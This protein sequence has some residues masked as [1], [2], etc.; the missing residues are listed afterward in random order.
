MILSKASTRLPHPTARQTRST[1]A[2]FSLAVFTHDLSL[3]LGLPSFTQPSTA[4]SQHCS[5]HAHV[6]A[7]NRLPRS[8]RRTRGAPTLLASCRGATPDTREDVGTRPQRPGRANRRATPPPPNIRPL[9]GHIPAA[10]A[11]AGDA[12]CRRCRESGGSGLF[13]CSARSQHTYVHP[14]TLRVVVAHVPTYE[15]PNSIC[16]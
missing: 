8:S 9:V 3:L 15:I 11:I 2:V 7:A 1:T 14:S 4:I 5:A 10:A 6:A 12:S 16:T 13:H